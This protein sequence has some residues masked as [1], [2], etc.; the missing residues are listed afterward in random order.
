MLNV[1]EGGPSHRLQ[2]PGLRL[3]VCPVRTDGPGRVRSSDKCVDKPS[4]STRAYVRLS[5]GRARRSKPVVASRARLLESDGRQDGGHG[6][7]STC[8]RRTT[9]LHQGPPRHAQVLRT[10]LR[11]RVQKALSRGSRV[12]ALRWNPLRSPEQDLCASVRPP[13]PPRATASRFVSRALAPHLRRWPRVR[14]AR[15]V[16]FVEV[17]RPSPSVQVTRCAG[18]LRPSFPSPA[19]DTGA[20]RLP[21]TDL[22]CALPYGRGWLSIPSHV[23]LLIASAPYRRLHCAPGRVTRGSDPDDK[24]RVLVMRD[25]DG[26]LHV[27]PVAEHDSEQSSRHVERG[28]RRRHVAALLGIAGTSLIL[29]A[30]LYVGAVRTH[31]GQRVDEAALIGRATHGSVQRATNQLLDT[32]SITSLVLGSI[33]LRSWR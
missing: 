16:G 31:F 23:R 26:S 28:N 1:P 11:V 3:R 15:V 14:V 19:T 13:R 24:M 10:R 12:S 27:S 20:N 6:F 4:L 29:L 30:G 21:C 2:C 5:R 25:R 8:L 22:R 7:A 32:I 18:L 33:A 17:L 9:C